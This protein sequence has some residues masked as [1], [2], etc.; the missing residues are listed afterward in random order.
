ML[1][2]VKLEFQYYPQLIE[3]M[4]EWTAVDRDTLPWAIQKCDYHNYEEY[5]NILEIK[6]NDGK[7]VPDTTLFCLDTERNILVGAVN[8][9]HCL[10]EYLLRCGGHIGDGIRPG[11]RGKGLGT[12]LVALALQECKK[13][14]ISKV[15]MC[16][17]KN[18]IASARTIIKNNGILENEVMVD[19]VEIQRYWIEM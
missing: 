5:V 17:N 14:G 12:Q 8:I 9:R 13:L 7:Y 4:D 19:S 6:E 11:E 16:C 10:S 1:K 3:M 18:N 15:L 2:L